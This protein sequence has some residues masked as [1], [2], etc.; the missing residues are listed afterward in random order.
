MKQAKKGYSILCMNLSYKYRLYPNQEQTAKLQ[1]N[2]A[3]CCFLYNSAL[4]ERN[5]FYKKYGKGISFSDQCKALPEI[6]KEFAEQTLSIYSQSLQ[7]VLKR[8]D[9]SYQNFFRRVKGKADKVGFPRYKSFDRFNSVVFP[10]SDLKSGGVKLLPNNKLKVF[11]IPGK[12]RVKL[13]RPFQ[14]RCK[15]VIIKK[16]G[17]KFYLIVSCDGVP[18]APLA[19]T[20]RTTAIDLGLTSFITTDD[21]TKFHHPKPYK[22]A[23]QKL[24]YLNRRLAAKQRGSNN[25]KGARRSLA[26]AYEKV[27][28]IRNDFLHKT[29]LQLV[30]QNDTVIIEKLNIKSMLEA[31]GFEVSKSNIQDASWGNFVALLCYKAERADKI[32][33]EVDPRNTSKTCSECGNIKDRLELSEREYHCDACGIAMDRDLNAALNIRGLG[34]SLGGAPAVPVKEASDL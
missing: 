19:K 1:G 11:G 15:Q 9:S 14:G 6:K 21:G 26:R 16:Q 5:S 4:Q 29:A 2:F 18:S 23:K 33:I 30:K 20:G 25:R 28:N 34:T 12:I 32:V 27:S 3:F 24:A 7:Q 8:L 17:D 10:Q 31:K 13:H 22:T